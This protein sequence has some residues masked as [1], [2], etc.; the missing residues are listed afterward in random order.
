[1]SLAEGAPLENGC[2]IGRPSGTKATPKKMGVTSRGSPWAR[3][4]W[5]VGP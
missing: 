4:S 5:P 3:F 1:L 2:K